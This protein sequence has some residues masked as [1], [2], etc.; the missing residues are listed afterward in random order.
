MKKTNHHINELGSQK[1]L[2][3]KNFPFLSR[4]ITSIFL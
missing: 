4:K 1:Y 2:F 3:I